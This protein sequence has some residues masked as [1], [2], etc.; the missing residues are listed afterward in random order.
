MRASHLPSPLLFVPFDRL[1]F[2][3]LT[4]LY[5][6]HFIIKR[7]F[8]ST[9]IHPLLL[10][11]LSSSLLVQVAFQIASQRKAMDILICSYLI[12]VPGCALLPSGIP[13]PL[14]LTIP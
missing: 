13:P 5:H 8:P 9:R 2:W 11:C 4:I 12:L 10:S 3:N 1:I 6:I 7:P 14:C